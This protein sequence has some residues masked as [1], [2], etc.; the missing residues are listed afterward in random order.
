VADSVLYDWPD[1]CL[2]FLN[3]FG[4]YINMINSKYRDL[5]P[6]EFEEVIV[7]FGMFLQAYEPYLDDN[8]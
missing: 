3:L 7:S 5:Y 6:A 8:Q 2:Y 4:N 1:L